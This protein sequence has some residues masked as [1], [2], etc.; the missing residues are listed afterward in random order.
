MVFMRF[1]RRLRAFA[2]PAWRVDRAI[3]FS[4]FVVALAIA[5]AIVFDSD[6]P[7]PAPAVEMMTIEGERVALADLRG[8]VVLVNF[9]A[10]DCA[11]CLKEMPAMAQLYRELKPR[12]LDAIF[13]AMP[14]DR[15]DHVLAYARSRKLPFKVAL[16][17]Q[18]NV[19]RAFGDIRATPT[20]LIV[21]KRG[22][23][24]QKILGEPDF[25]QLRRFI[26][27]KLD[28]TA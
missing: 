3:Y 11:V 7:R 22:Y 26:S 28:E 6:P 13:V 8:K 20:T 27:G 18:G 2:S 21:D 14:H 15:P 23:I 12:G 16:D 19:V 25:E 1:F 10:T 24:V 17:V 9:W 4:L 5:L